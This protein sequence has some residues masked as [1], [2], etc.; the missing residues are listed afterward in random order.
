MPSYP[1]HYN[2]GMPRIPQQYQRGYGGDMQA[3][4]TMLA[5][6][7]ANQDEQPPA[8]PQVQ[9]DESNP[10]MAQPNRPSPAGLSSLGR[11]NDMVMRKSGELASRTAEGK[12]AVA[13]AKQEATERQRLVDS[14]THPPPAAP[15]SISPVP[16]RYGPG[17]VLSSRYGTGS[18]DFAPPG[19]E[20]HGTF[21][22]EHM[23]FGQIGGADEARP[24][25]GDPLQTTYQQQM[26][27]DSIH[28]AL[29]KKKAA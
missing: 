21:G 25:S 18:E 12:A 23:Q 4:Q 15:Y 11:F 1:A 2:Y 22:P 20:V 13:G 16:G 27:L 26:I 9:Q 14:I 8:P 3:M 29:G 6:L 19:T 7:F 17:A 10:Y 28:K 5:Y 24:I